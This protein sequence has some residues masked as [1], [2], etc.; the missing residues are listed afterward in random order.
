VPLAPAAPI[1]RGQRAKPP[2]RGGPPAPATAAEDSTAPVA[3]ATASR[4]I[5]AEI[6]DHDRNQPL[7][8][9]D[10]YTIAFGVDVERRANAVGD[11]G[12]EEGTVFPEGVS[13]VELTVE[14]QSNDFDITALKQ[15]FKL[16]RAGQSK[17]KARFEITPKHEG[18]A[19]LTAIIHKE[20]N[21]VQ[22]MTIMLSVGAANA[23]P[24]ATTSAARPRSGVAQIQG[25]EVMIVMTPAVPSGYDFMAR[26]E[27]GIKTAHLEVEPDELASAITAAR[28]ALLDVVQHA[29]ETGED[30]FQTRI[31]LAAADTAA[32]LG[33]M[34]RAGARLFQ[35]LFKHAGGSQDAA[36]IG[37]WLRDL[38]SPGTD[39][40]SIQVMSKRAPVPWALL[41][42]GDVS[43]NATL[44]W[45]NFLGVRHV[46]EQLP[47]VD[48]LGQGGPAIASDKP[49]LEV[50]INLNRRIDDDFRADW[51]AKQE[52]FWTDAT[53]VHSRLHVT[54]RT[55]R[56]EFLTALADGTT[57][58]QI[59]YFYGHAESAALGAKG[60][61]DA[62]SLV[63]SDARLTLGD[64]NTLAPTDIKLRGNP[65]VFINAC[66]S[67]ELSPL[68]YDGF[69]PYFMAKGAR[70]VI[71]TECRTPGIFAAEWAQRFFARFLDGE[72][73]GTL[74][75]S[76]RRE[77]LERHGN[78]LGLLYAVHCDGD[79]Q[80]QPGL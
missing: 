25:R 1:S 30:V 4:W 35:V 29:D 48:Q 17:G 12:L 18:R 43:A 20:R 19:S 55:Q 70:G 38:V 49:C 39:A 26:D 27:R 2:Q 15:T 42:L 23:E 76:L 69:V 28:D 74:T 57:A 64:L 10:T 31:E 5:S 44:D 3:S 7:A 72:P 16:Q 65:L 71:G 59:V 75:L 13:D 80:V 62:S 45:Q 50:S 73:L 63:L 52:Q 53:G 41:Y 51:V 67:A 33:I 54:P 32:A 56:Q 68:F 22:Q 9:G 8:L 14:L 36:S 11:A 24:P 66:E 40:M 61:A 46:I 37:G 21:F 34:A 79:T 77:F 60:G 47:I 58:D 6:D 78:P